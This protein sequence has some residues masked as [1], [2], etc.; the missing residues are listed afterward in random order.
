METSKKTIIIPDDVSSKWLRSNSSE[1]SK[2]IMKWYCIESEKTMNISDKK[3]KGSS[4]FLYTL[5]DDKVFIDAI[6]SK[7]RIF[8]PKNANTLLI[9][10]FYVDDLRKSLI[11]VKS[12]YPQTLKCR[13]RGLLMFPILSDRKVYIIDIDDLKSSWL[14]RKEVRKHFGANEMENRLQYDIPINR[15]KA[16]D[17]SDNIKFVFGEEKETEEKPVEKDKCYSLF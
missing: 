13:K 9:D 7:L 10:K 1:I 6:K 16:F 8:L 14:I 2:I 12:E 5:I 17:I 3:L 4:F 15:M 11:E